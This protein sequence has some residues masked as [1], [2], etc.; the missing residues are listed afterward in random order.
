MKPRLKRTI[1]DIYT[2]EA[3]LILMRTAAPDVRIERPDG[4]PVCAGIQEQVVA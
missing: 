1:E 3:D 4:R 2:P